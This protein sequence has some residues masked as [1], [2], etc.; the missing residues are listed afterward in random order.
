LTTFQKIQ[1]IFVLQLV[2]VQQTSFAQ[3]TLSVAKPVKHKFQAETM[4]AT[5]MAVV[6]PGLG[7]IYNRKYWK[8]PLVYAGFGGLFYSAGYNSGNYT[9]YMK[10]YQ[11]FTDNVKETDSYLKMIA[12]DPS[13]YDPV[14]HPDTYNP[15]S[16]SHIKDEML[17]MVDYFKKYRDLSYIG[18]AGWY[19]LSVLDANVDA[20]LF[21]YDVS[22]NL[23]I[24]FYP[25]PIMLPGGFT[26][27]GINVGMRIIF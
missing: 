24:A 23:E 15:A 12:A 21:N 14:L 25:V 26:G 11:D 13:T 10:A 19:L 3:D 6:F 8:I 1:I 22:D 7:Q 17:R 2:C 9:K 4:K 16:A 5:M 27:A 18:I 20:S